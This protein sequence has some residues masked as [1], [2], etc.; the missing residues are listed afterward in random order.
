MQ[1]GPDRMEP[2]VERGAERFVLEGDE[3]DDHRQQ[4]PFDHLEH[5]S[6]LT[7]LFPGEHQKYP[8][9]ASKI[10]FCGSTAGVSSFRLKS[11][12]HIRIV[13]LSCDLPVMSTVFLK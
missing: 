7:G 13:M 9:L 5:A 1:M 6:Q 12:G 2:G 10:C 11:D 4:A 8:R 3:A